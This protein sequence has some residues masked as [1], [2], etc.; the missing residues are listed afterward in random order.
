[1]RTREEGDFGP[2]Y[3]KAMT[4]DNSSRYAILTSSNLTNILASLLRVRL[5][6]STMK[7][8]LPATPPQ[9]KLVD[10]SVNYSCLARGKRPKMKSKVRPL[11][12]KSM[13]FQI[14][15]EFFSDWV[16]LIVEELFKGCSFSDKVERKGLPKGAIHAA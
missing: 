6:L 7:K 13:S 16:I 2:K 4:A 14:F 12:L 3:K 9:P 10:A 8:S 15:S 5:A 11:F 1:M